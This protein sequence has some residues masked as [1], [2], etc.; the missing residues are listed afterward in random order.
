M[1][2]GLWFSRGRIDRGLFGFTGLAV[3][4]A[5]IAQICSISFLVLFVVSSLVYMFR[6]AR[7]RGL[8]AAGEQVKGRR[9]TFSIRRQ[10]ATPRRCRR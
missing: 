1:L 6:R 10:F 3:A 9:L 2:V 5:S 7:G 8:M 4:S